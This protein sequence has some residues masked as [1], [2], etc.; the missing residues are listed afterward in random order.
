MTVIFPTG[1]EIERFYTCWREWRVN[2]FGAEICAAIDAAFNTPPAEVEPWT[3]WTEADFQ[4][5]MEATMREPVNFANRVIGEPE[6]DPWEFANVRGHVEAINEQ[7]RTM[8]SIVLR[9]G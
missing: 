4:A 5:E 1:E 7:V 2:I 8:E 3:D 6:V 9:N